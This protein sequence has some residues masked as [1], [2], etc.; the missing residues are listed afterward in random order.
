MAPTPEDR[1][2]SVVQGYQRASEIISVALTM[3]LPALCGLWLDSWLGS[4][5]WILIGGAVLGLGSGFLQ[6]LRISAP[7]ARRRR[8]A[9]R[10]D[11]PVAE[12]SPPT[13]G[14]T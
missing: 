3:T 10:S 5:P 6:L 2:P 11:D 1:V 12:D 8:L 14:A 7:T 4:S 9:L 13:S